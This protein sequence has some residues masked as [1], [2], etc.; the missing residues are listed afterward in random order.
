MWDSAESDT[1]LQPIC[2][3]FYTLDLIVDKVDVQM[4]LEFVRGGF[5]LSIFIHDGEV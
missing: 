1:H 3:H 4:T 2:R 5:Q